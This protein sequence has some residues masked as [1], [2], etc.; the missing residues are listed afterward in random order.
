MSTIR[1]IR[2]LASTIMP[3]LDEKSRLCIPFI[4]ER[5]VAHRKRSDKP[6]FIG[7][8]GVQGAG[9]TT[10]VRCFPFSVTR[11]II[12]VDTSK[13]TAL[14]STLTQ[15]P[16]SLAIAIFSIDDIYLTHDAQKQ[17]A[18]SNPTNSLLQHRGQPSTHDLP[19]GLSLFSALRNHESNIRIP[20]YDKSAYQGHG[21]RADPS[22]WHTVNAE[23][24]QKVQVVLFEGWCVGFRPLEEGEL[25]RKWQTAKEEEE[26]NQGRGRLGKLN[27]EEIVTVNEALKKYNALTEYVL[28]SIDYKLCDSNGGCYSQLDA[29]VHM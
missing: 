22:S 5:L 24:E 12:S 1:C 26:R 2:H 14:H 15:P 10:L 7:L 23:G 4:S 27:F 20:A 6:F 17:L 16:Y 9:K 28:H 3:E 11:R 19:L 29:F 21:D 8:N 25:R 18:L 13:V